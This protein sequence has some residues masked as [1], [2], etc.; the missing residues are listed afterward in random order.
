MAK[1]PYRVL[2]NQDN[3]NL[4]YVTRE[5]LTPAHVDRMVDEVADGGADAFLLCPNAQRTNY[6]S[7]VWQTTWDGYR[8]GDPSFWGLPPEQGEDASDYAD[9]ISAREHMVR[10]M[11]RLAERCD[12]VERALTRCAQ[13]RIAPGISIRMNDMHDAPWPDS[14][15]HS[16]FYRQHPEWHLRGQA[17]RDWGSVGLDYAHRQVR[18][19][20]LALIGELADRYRFE[21]LELDFLRFAQYFDGTDPEGQRRTMTGFLHEVREVLSAARRPVALIARIASNPGAVLEL[22]FDVQAWARERAVD[23]ISCGSFLITGWEMPIDRYRRLVGDRIAV[24]ACT[25]S[26]SGRRGRRDTGLMALDPALVRGFAAGYLAAG[27]DGIELFNYFCVREDPANP[28][29]RF[30]VMGQIGALDRLR[31]AERRHLATVGVSNA[32]TDLPLQVPVKLGPCESRSFRLLLAR[33]EAGS[34]VTVE[35]ELDRDVP[36]DELH[37][38]IDNRPIGPAQAVAAGRARF[39]VPADAVGDGVNE[40]VLRV[41]EHAVVVSGIEVRFAA[42]GAG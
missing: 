42:A 13:R 21:L 34:A 22:G 26:A 16:A 9:R 5:P 7:A 2:Y 6:P 38:R 41:G 15:Q 14:H 11:Q 30:E 29:P 37:L 31:G 32:R 4:F 19:H 36:P 1:P 8:A 12:Y 35:V 33:G 23:A 3:S 27:A 39:D 10:Q 18:D 20:L 24:Y 28:D 17:G 40:L 25:D